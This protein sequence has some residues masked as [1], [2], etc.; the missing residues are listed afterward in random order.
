MTEDTAADI[1]FYLRIITGLLAFISS[2]FLLIFLAFAIKMRDGLR[3]TML[4]IDTEEGFSKLVEVAAE[5]GEHQDIISMC[6]N[7]L[8]KVKDSRYALWYLART[9][10]GLGNL[11]EAEEYA[12]RVFQVAPYFDHEYLLK[13]LKEVREKQVAQTD[14]GSAVD[15]K[16]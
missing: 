8:K 11:K 12:S 7:R 3:R 13:L 9:H 5:R 2:V 14:D 1:L 4:G 10:A 15:P 6:E 16:E